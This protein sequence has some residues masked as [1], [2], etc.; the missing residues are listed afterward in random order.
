[1]RK[2]LLCNRGFLGAT[3]GV[4]DGFQDINVIT[5]IRVFGDEFKNSQQ[6][7][8]RKDR[9]AYI[10]DSLDLIFHTALYPRLFE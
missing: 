3:E 6:R 7:R 10:V 9:A 1:M 5:Y 8:K 2:P 4:H